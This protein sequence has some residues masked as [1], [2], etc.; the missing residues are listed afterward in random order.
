DGETEEDTPALTIYLKR[1]TNVETD[2]V[3]L[4]RKTDVSADKHYAAALSNTSKV[5][6][7]KIKK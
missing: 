4:S 3:S 6:L 1:D 2:R 5:V 7:A